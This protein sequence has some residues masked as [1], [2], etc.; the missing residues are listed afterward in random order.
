VGVEQAIGISPLGGI[1]PKKKHYI[2]VV[3]I[4][5]KR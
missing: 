2:R 3:K 1:L 4:N 5:V